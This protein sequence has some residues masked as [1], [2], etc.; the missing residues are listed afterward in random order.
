MATF[1][2]SYDLVGKEEDYTELL[3]ALRSDEAVRILYSEWL[4][5][6][7][8]DAGSVA[9]RYVRYLDANDRIFACGVSDWAYDR[10]LN[11]QKSRPLLP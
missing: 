9:K 10:I 7:N 8:G 5:R 11:E 2:V 4:V 6:A 3:A 1:L